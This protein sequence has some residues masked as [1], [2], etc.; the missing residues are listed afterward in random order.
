LAADFRAPTP[1]AAAEL[2]VVE[3]ET[4]VKRLTEMR[5]RLVTVARVIMRNQSTA[6]DRFAGRLQ[7]PRKRLT[8]LWMRIDE[9]QR[10]LIAFTELLIG[11]RIKGLEAEG[12]AL[13]SQSPMHA[14]V[15]L[16]DQLGF[17][18]RTVVGSMKGRL[19]QQNMSLSLLEE[20]VKDLSPI[21]ILKRGYS[22]TRRL[23]GKKILKDASDIEEGDRVDVTLAR[24]ELEC[25]I[26]KVI[27]IQ[28]TL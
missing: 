21:S 13:I 28:E 14:I 11:N 25:R 19:W 27:F 16:K 17:Q 23:P 26:E 24:G 18:K 20:K 2:L 6:L 15:S 9:L 12:R 3:K 22:I 5:T 1:S 7:D 10:R 4:I 8:L